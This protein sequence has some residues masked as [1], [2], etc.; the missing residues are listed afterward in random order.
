MAP[1]ESVLIT[2]RAPVGNLNITKNNVCIGRELAAIYTNDAPTSNSINNEK[3]SF[4]V[5][6]DIA[7]N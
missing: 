1:A 7:E 5:T 3:L 6:A 4:M 2:V